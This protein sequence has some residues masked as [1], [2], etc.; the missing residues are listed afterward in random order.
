MQ[1]SV[2]RWPIGPVRRTVE[3]IGSRAQARAARVVGKGVIR[4]RGVLPFKALPWLWRRA[5][6]GGVFRVN[7][8]ALTHASSEE[9]ARQ[10]HSPFLMA[11][12]WVDASEYSRSN[13]EHAIRIG[14]TLNPLGLNPRLG[15]AER[16]GL[17]RGNRRLA[18]RNRRR[19]TRR[20]RY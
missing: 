10:Q 11:A 15:A 5:W 9:S 1:R 16:Q 7:P 20:P 4:C 6:W 2:M 3:V 12:A 13:P 8:R 17:D 18:H 14:F 19:G